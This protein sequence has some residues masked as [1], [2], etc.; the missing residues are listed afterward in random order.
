[1]LQNL[2][3]VVPSAAQVDILYANNGTLFDAFQFGAPTDTW[4]L[5]GQSFVMDIKASRDDA[6]PLLT[7]TSGAGQIIVDDATQRIVHFN[8]ADT[9]MNAAL[10]VGTYVYD[11]VM[12]DGSTPPIRIPLMEGHFYVQQ[13]V[14]ES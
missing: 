14:T 9:V 10:A 6:T 7:L 5:T 11:L 2:N 3:Y 8:V 4:T 13:G 12:F 1:M